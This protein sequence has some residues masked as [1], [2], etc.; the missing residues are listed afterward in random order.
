MEEDTIETLQT[1]PEDDS[2]NEVLVEYDITSYPSDLS[3]LSL[4]EMW[5]RNDIVIP[6]FQR[7]FVWKI[8]QSSL[9]IESF[10][11]GLPVPPIFFYIDDDNKSLVIDGQQRLL[12]VI[13]YFD[14]YFGPETSKG[15]RQIFRLTGLN[16]KSPFFN[17]RFSELDA[18]DRRKLESSVL[19]A[20]NIRQLTPKNESTS[21]YHIFERLNTGGTPLSP[22]EIRNCVFRGNFLNQLRRLNKD[23]Y[24]RHIISKPLLDT[25][26]KDVELIL[27]AFA[28]LNHLDLYEKPM[29]EFLNYIAN[30]YKNSN[31]PVVDKFVENFPKACE[32][33]DSLFRKKPF[34]V[35]GPLNTSIFDSVF[36]TIINNLNRLPS[37]LNERYENLLSDQQ[38]IDY[39]T[40][41]TTDEKTVKARFKYVNEKLIK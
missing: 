41:G 26:Q 7:E 3:L 29:K 27:R 13:F 34:S 10:L 18:K 11:V 37:N 39:T 5:Y 36:C 9:L 16:E 28:L 20:I 2:N 31:S 30:R 33:I 8:K 24:W 32:I 1:V 15:K 23:K 17:K 40:I 19:R 4:I 12:S 14:E 35:R 21:V 25:H 22:Q 6:D 38:F